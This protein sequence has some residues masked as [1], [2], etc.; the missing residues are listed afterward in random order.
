MKFTCIVEINLPLEK[1][2]ELFNNVDHLKEWQD[3]FISYTHLSGEVG[4]TGGKSRLEYKQGR[5]HIVLTET[6]LEN[7][8]PKELKALYEH[9]HM[10]N[11]MSNQFSSSEPNKTTYTA[12]IEYTKFIGFMPK[13]FAFL[14]PGMFKKQTQKWL[15]QFKSFA[16]KKVLEVNA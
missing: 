8:L 15:D 10:V 14:V 4:K 1:T 9:K 11:T 3:G 2:V 5:N 13:L 12:Y 6:I 16:E 7:N